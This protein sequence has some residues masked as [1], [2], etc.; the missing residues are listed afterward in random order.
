M[1]TL[2][3][4]VCSRALA[5]GARSTAFLSTVK[6]VFAAYAGLRHVHAT[7][8]RMGG[9]IASRAHCTFSGAGLATFEAIIL[10]EPQGIRVPAVSSKWSAQGSAVRRP[11][12]TRTARRGSRKPGWRQRSAA[13]DSNRGQAQDR[14]FCDSAPAGRA[15][16]RE[17]L[18]GVFRR[19]PVG[20]DDALEGFAAVAG[21][22]PLQTIV[23][24]DEVSA[25][26][27][28]IS[29]RHAARPFDH[30]IGSW[31]RD[32]S[33]GTVGTTLLYQQ[34]GVHVGEGSRVDAVRRDL[35]HLSRCSARA[36]Q[37]SRVDPTRQ[38]PWRSKL[39][40][41]RVEF[42]DGQGRGAGM[43]NGRGGWQCRTGRGSML[44][45]IVPMRIWYEGSG[46]PSVPT[47]TEVG[48]PAFPRGVCNPRSR[49]GRG[50]GEV[51]DGKERLLLSLV[52][53][54]CASLDD[55]SGGQWSCVGTSGDS[56]API[57]VCCP[58]AVQDTCR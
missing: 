13:P 32:Q 21:S 26:R 31:G 3:R 54:S 39:S 18:T 9:G 35:R 1:G 52:P 19:R 48:A 8:T 23:H 53:M 40:T 27:V 44:F 38:Q 12:A 49:W 37:V 57:W 24:P 14:G 58:T 10:A 56:G 42:N 6:A 46:P 4:S 36:A 34:P 47:V 17:H 33:E 41:M 22:Q 16:A 55:V 29:E 45:P 11:R 20:Q 15:C 50:T 30:W 5:F 25:G 28:G 43:R 51:R 7:R 2:Q